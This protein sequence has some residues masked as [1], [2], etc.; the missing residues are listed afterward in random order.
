M[1]SWAQIL[2]LIWDL[3]SFE[4]RFIGIPVKKASW[5]DII[6]NESVPEQLLTNDHPNLWKEPSQYQVTFWSQLTFFLVHKLW[7]R[8]ILKLASNHRLPID[9]WS[10]EMNSWLWYSGFTKKRTNKNMC[11]ALGWRGALDSAPAYKGA[12]TQNTQYTNMRIDC[13]SG[14]CFFRRIFGV[15]AVFWR[16]FM[17]CQSGQ[18]YYPPPR[19]D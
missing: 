8:H 9:Y 2:S 17:P 3:A 14:P 1:L 10:R 15:S 4:I 7:V 19:A 18:N 5:S 6:S 16:I 13:R 12:C 11:Y